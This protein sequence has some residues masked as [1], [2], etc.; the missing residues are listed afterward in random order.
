L[1]ELSYSDQILLG[2]IILI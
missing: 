1:A 2:R